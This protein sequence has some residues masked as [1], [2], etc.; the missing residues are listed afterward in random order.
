MQPAA[1]GSP[2]RLALA[3]LIGTALTVFA[4]TPSE[5]ASTAEEADESISAAAEQTVAEPTPGQTLGIASIVNLRDLGG[6][7]TSDGATVRR[8]LV[9]RSN[10]LSGITESDMEKLAALGL[11]VDYDLRTAEER[12][13]RPDELP[14]GVEDV[15]L[16][17]LA[18]SPQAGPAQLENLIKDPEAA[19]AALGGGKVAAGFVESYKEF[20]SLPSAQAEFRKLFLGLGDEEKLPALFLSLIHI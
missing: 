9:Y 18:D 12:E 2:A 16:D 17:V 13:K 10:Q 11:K 14:P 19:N 3:C 20:V 4:C 6:Y 7:Q 1:L 8:G 15:W 5:T